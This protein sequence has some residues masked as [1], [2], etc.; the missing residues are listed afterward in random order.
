M[1]AAVKHTHPTEWPRYRLQFFTL[2]AWEERRNS[3]EFTLC[4]KD[5]YHLLPLT[6]TLHPH[7]APLEAHLLV[8]CHVFSLVP[9]LRVLVGGSWVLPPYNMWPSPGWGGKPAPSGLYP[10]KQNGKTFVVKVCEELLQGYL[11]RAT[12]KTV[13]GNKK[14]HW[15][16]TQHKS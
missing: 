13:N 1:K 11:E 4:I 10:G 14:P 3:D 8:Q 12:D 9:Q 5:L 7:P 2:T 16:L 15:Q 6:P